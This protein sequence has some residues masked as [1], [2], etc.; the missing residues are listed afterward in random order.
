MP[1]EPRA[2]EGAPGGDDP[3][4][5]ALT[6]IVGA[7]HVLVEAGLR[8]PYETDWTRRWSGAARCV[9]RPGSTAEVAAV[10]R[11]V[12]EHGAVVV[13][14]GGNTGLVGGGVPRGG[15][16]VLSL[17]R[18]TDLEPV[19][20]TAAQV[21]AGAG[22]T[23]ADLH[24][25]A[26][27]AGLAYGVDL[28]SRD[29]ATVGGTVATN[30]G[31]TRV[32]RH[33]ATR[34]QVVGVEAVLADGSVVRRLGGLLKDTVGYDLP[35]LLVGSEGTL[36]LVTRARLRLV[37]APAHRV[38][39]LLA[40]GSVADAQALLRRVRD[41]GTGLEAAELVHH[42]GVELVA[43]QVGVPAPFAAAHPSYLLL[44]VA[45]DH[46]PT[47]ELAAVVADA[48]EVRDAAVAGDTAGRA[49]LWRVREAHTEAISAAGVPVKLDLAVAPGRLAELDA[50]LPGVVERAAP[51]ARLI[52]FGHVGD[53]NLHVNVLDVDAAHVE[54][55]EAA[56]LRLAVD[57]GGTISAEHG[58]GTH[59][60]AHV[61]LVRD[62]ADLAAMRAIKRALDP[63]G[64]LNPGAVLPPA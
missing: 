3:L 62:P 2:G 20:P 6:G 40:V 21:T 34:A 52:V 50:A 58:V 42:A 48:G 10:V 13:P 18:L 51:G 12:G 61:G 38:V 36:G 15:E 32:L 23:I 45:A 19:E 16:V 43:E 30:A 28:A 46:D 26:A 33:G 24:A 25:H 44:E 17:A 64:L 56:L 49:R 54:R 29:T 11:A 39:A 55:L 47:D 22:V 53:G 5:A 14:Q 41:R 59:K 60:A 37:P 57:L 4:V 27:A 1:G 63:R 9:V 8:V 35:G 31:G 7:R